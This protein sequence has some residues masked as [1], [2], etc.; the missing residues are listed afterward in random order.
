MI[1]ALLSAKEI[2]ESIK[3]G[4]ISKNLDAINNIQMASGKDGET[5]L[6]PLDYPS[7]ILS[8]LKILSIADACIMVS[9]SE[10]TALDAELAIAIDNA[11]IEEGAVIYDDFSDIN[12]FSRFFVK[13]KVGKFNK[14]KAGETPKFT[15]SKNVLGET[16]NYISIDKHFIVK[17]I[18]SVILG[19]TLTGAVKKGEKFFLVPSGKEVTVKSIQVMDVDS[20]TAEKG[21]HVGLALNNINENDLEINYG[22]SSSKSF[23]ETYLCKINKSEFF[24][25]DP[26][27]SKGLCCS[28]LGKN[29][30][31]SISDKK[32]SGTFAFN[33]PVLK[34]AGRH[35][36][37][38]ASLAI[39]KNRIV[40]NFEFA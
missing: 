11:D 9:N 6:Y 17:G 29:L 5:I 13:N 24:K 14:F 22:L 8:V 36:L 3:R 10:I 23:S 20:A 2:P 1:I 21:T 25:G 34:I 26:T 30:T 28:I 40:G 19:F 12:F 27:V 15:A 18:G 7:S 4:I 37:A 38:D 39:G 16:P 35:I 32:G 33:K 31:I